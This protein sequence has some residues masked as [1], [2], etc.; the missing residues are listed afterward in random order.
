MRTPQSPNL[1]SLLA[2]N[3]LPRERVKPVFERSKGKVMLV[4]PK[5]EFQQKLENYIKDLGFQVY[6]VSTV[7]EAIQSL[8]QKPDIVI[9]NLCWPGMEGLSLLKCTS[10]MN[11]RPAFIM[12]TELN[13]IKIAVQAMKEGAAEY[14]VKPLEIRKLREALIRATERPDE[15]SECERMKLVSQMRS[16]DFILGHTESARINQTLL[17]RAA[18]SD[19]PIVLQGERGTYKGIL[20]ASIHRMG[21]NPAAPF[22]EVNCTLRDQQEVA[23]R[24]FG[25]VND[26]GS[27]ESGGTE[28][29]GGGTLFLDGFCSLS[30]AIQLGLMRLLDE[31]VYCRQGSVEP[32]TSDCRIIAGTQCDLQHALKNE[33]L[34]LDLF[35]RLAIIP[36]EIPPLRCRRE[37]LPQMVRTFITRICLHRSLPHVDVEPAAMSCLVDHHRPGNL[38]ELTDVLCKAVEG[39]KGEKISPRVIAPLFQHDFELDSGS[40]GLDDVTV[41]VEQ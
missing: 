15:G 41:S 14:L 17:K 27:T 29:A 25:K 18:K 34:R 19:A 2:A 20:A 12:L 26:D 5:G 13:S 21:R 40:R 3:H 22:V 32:L 10:D 35:Y 11:E 31:G 7:P 33:Q 36:V 1:R 9:C 28:K 24:L 39:S 4:H 16:L 23:A 6:P 38:S 30:N 8:R 37:E